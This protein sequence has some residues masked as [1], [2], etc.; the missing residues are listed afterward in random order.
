MPRLIL[1]KWLYSIPSSQAL[2]LKTSILKKENSKGYRSI[3][4]SEDFFESVVEKTAKEYSIAFDLPKGVVKI[5]RLNLYKNL[6]ASIWDTLSM[7]YKE[8]A[9]LKTPCFGSRAIY[10]LP[11]VFIK[12]S[13]VPMKVRKV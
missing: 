10:G 2:P 11:S 7:S 13:S 4:P 8:G 12:G 5:L 3:F 1:Y 6:D 9:L